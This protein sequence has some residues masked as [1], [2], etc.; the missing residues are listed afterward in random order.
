[1]K[2]GDVILVPNGED[3]H[4]GIVEEYRYDPEYEDIHCAQQRKCEWVKV[5]KRKDMNN[6]V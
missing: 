4:I 3:C 6:E 5:I 2:A 1:M